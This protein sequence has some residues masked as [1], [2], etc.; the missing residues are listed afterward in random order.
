[1]YL[2]E[3][4]EHLL[5]RIWHAT[6]DEATCLFTAWVQS[7]EF[8]QQIRCATLHLL[9]RYTSHTL[10]AMTLTCSKTTHTRLPKRCHQQS[11]SRSECSTTASFSW[12]R[13]LPNVA[14]LYSFTKINTMTSKRSKES[15][16]TLSPSQTGGCKNHFCSEKIT[17]LSWSLDFLLSRS[18]LWNEGCLRIHM[19][20]K[21]A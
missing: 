1:M 3:R 19:S 5:R 15:D 9:L 4:H 16:P 8:L 21:P 6:L 14:A 18:L 2:G 10:S 12:C 11:V 7:Y 20:L 17:V 13:Q